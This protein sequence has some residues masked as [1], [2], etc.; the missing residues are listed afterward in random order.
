MKRRRKHL[1]SSNKP[2][3]SD[4][5]RQLA[6]ALAKHGISMSVISKDEA[7]RR[8]RARKDRLKI[9]TAEDFA[10]LVF[11]NWFTVHFTYFATGEGCTRGLGI[12]AATDL[13]DLQRCIDI[14]FGSFYGQCVEVCE[15]VSVLPGYENLIPPEA[16]SLIREFRSGSLAAMF[17]FHSMVHANY[18]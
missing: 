5:D 4:T 12:W 15:G 10:K 17:S 1:R 3:V 16:Q 14:G 11:P 8:Q 6:K 9:F 13:A 18:S 7:L 2:K